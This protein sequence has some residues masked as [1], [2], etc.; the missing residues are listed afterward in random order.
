M[1]RISLADSKG[2][3]NWTSPRDSMHYQDYLLV[4]PSPRLPLRDINSPES[5]KGAWER[6][7]RA[8]RGV[9]WIMIGRHLTVSIHVILDIFRRREAVVASNNTLLICNTFTK[10]GTV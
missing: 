7:G 9:V 2:R 4:I 3:A 8:R 5:A 10:A 1:V 6:L